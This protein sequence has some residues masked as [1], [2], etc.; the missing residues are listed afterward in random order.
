MA[1]ILLVADDIAEIS[2]VK[3]VLVRAGHQTVLA[4]NGAD[5]AAA[6][7]REAP[8]AAIVSSTCDGAGGLELARNLAGDG[9][10][11][12]V[13]VL[14]LGESAAAPEA[15][16]QLP[17]PVDPAQ[18][19]DELS[20]A[21][22]A[23]A[24]AGSAGK[25]PSGRIRLTAIGPGSTAAPRPGAAGR[26]AERPAADRAAAADALRQRAEELRRAGKKAVAPAEAPP[27]AEPAFPWELE[28]PQGAG[29]HGPAAG[30]EPAADE[31]AASA[32][33]G[34]EIDEELA[35]LTRDDDTPI[36]GTL[37]AAE[38]EIDAAEA[39]RAQAAKQ[40]TRQA[41]EA[42]RRAEEQAARQAEEARR[43]AQAEEEAAREAQEAQRRAQAEE[44]AAR[45]AAEAR[46]RAEAEEEAAREAE[47][48]ARRALAE[49]AAARA[50]G[51]E[52]ARRRALQLAGERKARAA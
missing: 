23:A 50:A 2:A 44:Q 17:R 43:R 14:L 9:A 1:R 15:A 6:V 36:P 34:A 25:P 41:E 39:R 37:A 45:E 4:T 24:R 18:L 33:L 35:R 29:R 8:Q 30:G 19:A 5:A 27:P 49:R 10:T 42:R 7:A 11:A 47:A 52:A 38:E 3:R 51:E 12:A 31:D 21:L 20:R 40:A 32:K 48:E 26:R 22:E 46:R 16:V 13:P 28:P